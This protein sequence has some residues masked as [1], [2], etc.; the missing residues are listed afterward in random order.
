MTLE[1]LDRAYETL[2]QGRLEAVA[3]ALERGD[4]PQAIL[5]LAMMLNRII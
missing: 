2:R 5:V 3:D 4:L 1:E